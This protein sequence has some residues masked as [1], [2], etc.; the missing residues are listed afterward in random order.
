MQTSV[1]TSTYSTQHNC[2]QTRALVHRQTD[3][4][5]QVS[6]T[7]VYALVFTSVQTGQCTDVQR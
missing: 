3:T 6:D 2:V 4:N 7:L 1:Q 5:T